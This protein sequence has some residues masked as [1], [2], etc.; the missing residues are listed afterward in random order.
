MRSR[1]PLLY[2][3]MVGRYLGDGEL[4]QQHTAKALAV[5]GLAPLRCRRGMPAA[6]LRPAFLYA[7]REPAPLANLLLSA[8][9]ARLPTPPRAEHPQQ[10]GHDGQAE[11]H[12]GADGG[13]ALAPADDAAAGSSQPGR[14]APPG[15]A[16]AAG[17]AAGAQQGPG[18]AAPMSLSGLLMAQ[19][20][21]AME[22]VRME[23]E[24]QLEREQVRAA[25]AGGRFGVQGGDVRCCSDAVTPRR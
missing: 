17:G 2:H 12:G 19:H 10:V 8:F 24:R 9:P 4:E 22:F 1:A 21:R 15:R 18:A 13:G 7:S 25:G 16:G 3:D 5:A 23:R 11:A 14:Q 20:D 6:S